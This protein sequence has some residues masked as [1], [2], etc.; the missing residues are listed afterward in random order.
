MPK[1][2]LNAVSMDR[3]RPPL[4]L[5]SLGD[6]L[7]VAIFGAS[8]GLGR[9]FVDL[10]AGS[11]KVA[12]I[13]AFSRLQPNFSDPK[14][15]WSP[16]DLE[17]EETIARAAVET[18]MTAC[19]FDLVLVATGVLHEVGGLQP[20]KSWRALDAGSLEKAFTVNSIGPALIRC[21][22]SAVEQ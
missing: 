10:L 17:R 3:D 4:R 13:A 21:R 19:S 2:H 9:A 11:A 8:G 5:S 14:I 1:D 15:H 7:K 12:H 20:E 6:A 18:S 22:R 16:V